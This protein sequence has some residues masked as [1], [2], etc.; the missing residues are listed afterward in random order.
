MS[1]SEVHKAKTLQLLEE[2]KKIRFLYL[3][4]VNM[5]LNK[6][7]NRTIEVQIVLKRQIKYNDIPKI[8]CTYIFYIN[9]DKVDN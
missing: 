9:I 2:L 3:K 1:L 5:Y 8:K 7:L 6:Y 4:K